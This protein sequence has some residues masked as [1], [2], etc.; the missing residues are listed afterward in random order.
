[1]WGFVIYLVPMLL[2]F[3]VYCLHSR[4]HNEHTLLE[5][6]I[7]ESEEGYSG[8]PKFAKMVCSEVGSIILGS[9]QFV[10]VGI[11]IIPTRSSG[12]LN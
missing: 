1:M 10:V 8:R 11:S 6:L 4:T 9:F 12:G 5:F 3:I 2:N 7:L